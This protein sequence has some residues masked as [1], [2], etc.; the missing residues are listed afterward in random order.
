MTYQDDTLRSPYHHPDPAFLSSDPADNVVPFS[1]F[2][3]TEQHLVLTSVVQDLHPGM[4]GVPRRVGHIFV[5][6]RRAR[7]FRE[8]DAGT[9]IDEPI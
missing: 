7:A 8:R 9:Y 5:G 6:Y 4:N 3:V 1:V 2:P